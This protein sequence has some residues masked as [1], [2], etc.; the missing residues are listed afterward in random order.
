ML[1]VSRCK[2]T[3]STPAFGSS[4][5]AMRILLLKEKPKKAAGTGQAHTTYTHQNHKQLTSICPE[6][7]G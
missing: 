1:D 3:K 5:S 4:A 6:Y 2:A 7:F